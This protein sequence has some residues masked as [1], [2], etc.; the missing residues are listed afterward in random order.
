MSILAL[1]VVIGLVAIPL[2]LWWLYVLI[3]AVRTPASQWAAADQSQVVHVLLMVFLGIVGTVLY[4]TIARPRMRSV[5]P[6]S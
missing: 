2:F 1:A 3:E 6:Q 4:L 5:G